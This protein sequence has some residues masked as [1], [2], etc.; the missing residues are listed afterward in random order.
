MD[1]SMI[2]AATTTPERLARE[3]GVLW[4]WAPRALT[5]ATS[6]LALSHCRGRVL[7][8]AGG[9]EPPEPEALEPWARTVTARASYVLLHGKAAPRLAEAIGIGEQRPLIVRCADLEDAAG[10]AAKLAGRGSTVLLAPGCGAGEGDAPESF[11]AH[12]LG[13]W[14]AVA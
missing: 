9:D 2:D 7:L 14:T 11:R 1:T 13:R 4:S 10:T 5:P 6:A 12:V 3:E 8:I